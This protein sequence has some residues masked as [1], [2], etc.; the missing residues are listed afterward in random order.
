[1]L[2]FGA[3]MWEFARSLAK[4][5]R[6]TAPESTAGYSPAVAASVP[7][8]ASGLA[9]PFLGIAGNLW[10]CPYVIAQ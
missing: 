2:I 8:A 6:G 9:G 3:V 7:V 10:K 1:M 4:A 5:R